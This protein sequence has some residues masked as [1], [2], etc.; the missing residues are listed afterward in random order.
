MRIYDHGNQTDSPH[1]EQRERRDQVMNRDKQIMTPNRP[2]AIACML[3]VVLAAGCAR[4]PGVGGT[5]GAPDT[6]HTPRL[7][8]TEDVA[9]DSSGAEDYDPWQSFNEKM[10]A[11]NHDVLDRY[12]VK[13]AAQGW[14]HVMP[15]VARRS[16]SR[17]F[18]N[19]D[20]PRRFVNN[21]LQA[22]PLGAGRE[23]ARFAVNTTVGL[24]GLFDVATPL[25]IEPSN[26][27]AGETLALYGAD[28]GPYLV[29]PTMPP[30]T[31]R[32]AIGNGIDGL[33]D[34]ISYF[35]P[36]V[37][38]RAKSIVTAVNER[39][40]NLQ[41]YDNVEDSVLDLYTAAR[42]GY[43]QRRRRAIELAMQGRHEEWMWATATPVQ[44]QPEQ[45]E[46]ARSP[47]TENPT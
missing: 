10:F 30:S 12:L 23:L 38:N 20:M 35:L 36:F 18:D 8:G 31:V 4:S 3:A 13:P 24:G 1:I 47:R 26:A 33:L 17:L 45:T 29:L 39:S 15:T 46:T 16:I 7:L 11:F 22:R 2:M 25:H 34:P 32:D 44:A 21:L 40:L 6:V 41:L 28:S 19:L 42:N 43:L 27:D 9:D 5:A 37:A 14:S